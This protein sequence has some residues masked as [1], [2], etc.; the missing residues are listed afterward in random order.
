MVTQDEIRGQ[1]RKSDPDPATS[2]SGAIHM[3]RLHRIWSKI[4]TL[5]YAGIEDPQQSADSVSSR[6]TYLRTELDA[7]YRAIPPQTLLNSGSSL[8]INN[9]WFELSYHHSILLLYRRRITTQIVSDQDLSLSNTFLECSRSAREMCHCY[10]KIYVGRP[11][12]YTW[13]ALHNLFLAGLTYLHC[14]WTSPHV[15]A[16]IK[17]DDLSSTCMACTMVL[18][19]MAER[20]TAAAP[21]RD[22]FEALTAKTM[23]MITDQ[24]QYHLGPQVAT[25]LSFHPQSNEMDMSWGLSQWVT[26]IQDVEMSGDME[27]FF[28]S[29]MGDVRPDTGIVINSELA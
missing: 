21:Y 24:E 4:H 29:L 1:P 26:N 18:V 17:H 3:F 8:W 22:I 6:V 19:V 9:E 20:W 14:I 15:R 25:G 7:W 28:T 12:G 16:S 5:L 11:L 23:S 2:M 13:E 10:R 27:T